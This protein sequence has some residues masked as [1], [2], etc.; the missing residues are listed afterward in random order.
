M[1]KAMTRTKDRMHT[2]VHLAIPFGQSSLASLAVMF[3]IPIFYIY[4]LF[5]PVLD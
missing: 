2:S 5:F 3:Q 4:L 1:N